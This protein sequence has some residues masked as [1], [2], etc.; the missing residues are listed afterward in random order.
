MKK[1]K[2]SDT[3]A[4]YLRSIPVEAKH[5]RHFPVMRNGLCTSTVIEYTCA[6]ATIRKEIPCPTIA[7]LYETS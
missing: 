1:K 2:P 7:K 4:N 5:I 6:G 3:L